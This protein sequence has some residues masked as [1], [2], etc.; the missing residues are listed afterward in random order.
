MVIMVM[1][2]MYM[3]YITVDCCH[4]LVSIPGL[5]V[6]YRFVLHGFSESS[7]LSEVFDLSTLDT[8]SSQ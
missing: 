7:S 6:K 8:Y 3:H 1:L 5:D 2:V 4:K